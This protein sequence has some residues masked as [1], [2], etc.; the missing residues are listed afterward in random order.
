MGVTNKGNRGEIIRLLEFYN[1]DPYNMTIL[2]ELKRTVVGG[3]KKS[4]YEKPDLQYIT[5]ANEYK[6]E[7]IKALIGRDPSLA[8]LKTI[9]KGFIDIEKSI[10]Q[11]LLSYPDKVK[12]AILSN[13]QE[14]S[15]ELES[16]LREE[17]ERKIK[18]ELAK[19]F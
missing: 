15:L 14:A 4:F 5:K 9:R 11:I 3:K 12:A 18:E 17:V 13:T 7:S 8:T 6:A 19:I 10:N 16:D 2:E 1:L